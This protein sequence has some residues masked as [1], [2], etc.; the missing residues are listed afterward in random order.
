[1]SRPAG[2]RAKP[3]TAAELVVQARVEQ[4][5]KQSTLGVAMGYTESAV[6]RVERG[7]VPR[8]WVL[9]AALV[10][11]LGIDANELLRR[12]ARGGVR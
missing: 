1:M 7:L 11:E 6:R 9:L 4:G 10:D 3:G 5:H 12:V 2:T 8:S